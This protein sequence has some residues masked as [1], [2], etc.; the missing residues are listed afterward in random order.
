VLGDEAVTPWSA[1]LQH[2]ARALIAREQALYDATAWKGCRA[3]RITEIVEH[4][5][6]AKSLTLAPV[7]GDAA[8]VKVDAGPVCHCGVQAQRAAPLHDFVAQSASESRPRS[9][10]HATRIRAGRMTSAL[11]AKQVGDVVVMHAPYGTF[12]LESTAGVVTTTTRW[13]LW[14]AASASRPSWRWRARRAA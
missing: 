5:T 8:S 13:R 12:T 2:F 4:G 10:A 6:V 11:D 1:V 7:D 14:R 3:F 9:I